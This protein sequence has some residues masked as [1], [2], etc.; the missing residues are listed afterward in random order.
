MLSQVERMAMPTRDHAFDRHMRRC[1]RPN[2]S[3][4]HYVSIPAAAVHYY[5]T[6]DGKRDGSSAPAYFSKYCGS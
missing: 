1:I 5:R 2:E 6:P 3:R 4:T